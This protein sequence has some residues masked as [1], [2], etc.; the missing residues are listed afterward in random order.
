MKTQINL[1]IRA[2][3]SD[4]S[5]ST[6]RGFESL[7]SKMR[8]GIQISLLVL[9]FNDTSALEGHFVSS[10]R[11]RDKRDRRDSRGDE[12]EGKGKKRE[13]KENEGTEE[14]ITFSPTLTCCKD[15]SPCPTVS[16]YQLDAPVTKATGHLCLTQPP[17]D[18]DQIM[19]IRRLI[20]ICA[21]HTC[22]KV[23]FLT[24]PLSFKQNSWYVSYC[25]TKI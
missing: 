7:A 4:S 5:Q 17:L 10:P 13:M 6:W 1:R 23:R 21:G 9:G 19:R 18:S 11:E 15:S 25:P 20:W 3:W 2:V 8:P 12:R 22:L 16:Q 14:I 24:L